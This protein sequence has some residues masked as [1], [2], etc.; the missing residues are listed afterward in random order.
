[1]FYRPLQSA[2]PDAI[3]PANLLLWTCICVLFAVLG[4]FLMRRRHAEQAGFA[5]KNPR[6]TRLCLFVPLLFVCALAFDLSAGIR[7]VFGIVLLG[8]LFVLGL[9]G[10][11]RL[12]LPEARQGRIRANSL[13][14]ALILA[15]A[16][17]AGIGYGSYLSLPDTAD[18][19]GIR[20]SY[21]GSPNDVGVPALGSSTATGYYFSAAY[22]YTETAEIALAK[23]LH[24]QIISG[25]RHALATDTKDFGNTTV[26]YDVC[27]TYE[28]KNGKTKTWYYDRATFAQL[29]SM[30][31][32][33]D[34]APVRA[35]IAAAFSGGSADGE[36]LWTQN[37]YAGGDLYLADASYRR[38]FSLKLTPEDRRALLACIREDVLAQT[39]ESRYFPKGE[40][41]GILMFTFDAEQDL[42]T[43]SYH[44]NN[45]FVYIEEGFVQTRAFLLEKDL[46]FGEDV[47]AG[48]VTRPEDVDTLILQRYDPYI[49]INKPNFPQSLY[50]MSYLSDS[51]DAFRVQK[52]FGNADVVRD[53]EE[54]SRILS[55]IR[56]N[57]YLSEPGYLVTIKYKGSEQW[58][59]KFWPGGYETAGHEQG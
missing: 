1:M 27:F 17:L 32:L 45:A 58:V 9:L 34:T 52:D 22:T 25:G 51:P 19:A 37:V 49:G 44:L 14:A 57:Y 50:F 59:Y 21:V 15:L 47:P 31:A 43:F 48:S 13:R 26:P 29:R 53:P 6:M 30:L 28:L 39:T 40:P 35:G 16:V 4:L 42:N 36:Q 33:D 56:S 3:A 20:V 24:E 23:T 18:V 10:S 8:L 5:G 54:I 41:L 7:L 38:I 55:E 12:L 46:W 2:V 11:E